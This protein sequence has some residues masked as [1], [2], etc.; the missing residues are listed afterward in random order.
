ME[1]NENNLAFVRRQ[2]DEWLVH[3]LPKLAQLQC[4]INENDLTI[5]KD[6]QRFLSEPIRGVRKSS[7]LR[8]LGSF[9]T[10]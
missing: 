3:G 2:C 9:S 8:L 1:S 6:W 5:E 7:F 10:L 4:S